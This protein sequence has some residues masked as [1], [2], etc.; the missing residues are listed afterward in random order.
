MFF[1]KVLAGFA[2]G[3][4][5]GY[6]L[7][8]FSRP[9]EIKYK[10]ISTSKFIELDGIEYHFIQEGKGPD[11]LL[12]HGIGANLLCWRQIWKPLTKFYRVT[13]LDLPGFG[14]SSKRIDIDYG[15]DAQTDRVASFLEALEITKAYVVGCSLGGAISLWL[16]KKRPEL[17]QRVVAIAPAVHHHIIRVDTKRYWI[18]ANILKHIFLNPFFVGRILRYVVA[19]HKDLTV[20]TILDYYAPYHRSPAAVFTFWRSFELI[21]DPRLPQDL[22]TVD[23]PVLVLY[24]RRDRMI[25]KIF[26]ENLPALMS[27][28]QVIYH[29]EGGHHLMNDEP[30]FVVDEVKKFLG[31]PQLTLIT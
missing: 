14:H 29:D 15:L 25:K 17:V 1:L 22:S 24:G 2:I 16:A 7:R 31:V 11:L 13:A 9:K 23:C 28:A 20:E 6:L 30:Q 3:L 26:I 8:V 21:K 19:K 10:G 4:L 12:I 27:D 18:F 5:A